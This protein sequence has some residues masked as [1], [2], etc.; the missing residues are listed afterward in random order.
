MASAEVIVFWIIII[1]SVLNRHKYW[2][3][4]LFQPVIFMFLALGITT[5]V[6]IGYLVPFPG[7][8]VRY[9]AIPELLILCSVISITR[10]KEQ[11]DYNKI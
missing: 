9:K 6:F 2:K 5:Y 4:R 7:A 3:V 11:T 1:A 8:I 10:W